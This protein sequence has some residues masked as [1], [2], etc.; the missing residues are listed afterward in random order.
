MNEIEKKDRIFLC[1]A[2]EDKAFQAI[3]TIA[4]CLDRSRRDNLIM[5][6]EV[7]LQFYDIASTKV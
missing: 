5:E 2:S 6:D 7:L 3:M 4:E 1:N